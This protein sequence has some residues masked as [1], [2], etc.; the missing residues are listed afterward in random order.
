MIFILFVVDAQEERGGT[1][2]TQ[3]IVLIIT[4]WFWKLSTD[5]LAMLC[6]GFGVVYSFLQAC[7]LFARYRVSD[8]RDPC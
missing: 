8:P 5:S 4:S 1:H 6:G 3:K 7:V 2:A